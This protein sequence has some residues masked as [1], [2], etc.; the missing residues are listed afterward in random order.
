[1]DDTCPGLVGPT[2]DTWQRERTINMEH[3]L[4]D[5]PIPVSWSI[6]CVLKARKKM[7]NIR[8]MA[9]FFRVVRD[10]GMEHVVL[11]SM[12]FA[13]RMGSHRF[14]RELDLLF[15]AVEELKGTLSDSEDA[16]DDASSTGSS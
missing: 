7:A 16:A 2:R 11:L 1:M 14:I 10:C 5:T 3:S 13:L 4:L 15:W 9:G 12:Y 8:D 6:W